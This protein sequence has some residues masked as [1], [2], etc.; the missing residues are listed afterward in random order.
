MPIING[1]VVNW[2]RTVDIKQF[3]NIDGMSDSAT[4]KRIVSRIRAAF[5]D[6]EDTDLCEICWQFDDVETLDDL[7]SALAELYDWA[8][9]EL[10]WLG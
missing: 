1:K 4:A 9:A 7:N 8:D 3:L 6:W 2:K 10:V 5:P